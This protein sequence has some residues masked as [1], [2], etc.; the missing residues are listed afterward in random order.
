MIHSR[1][2]KIGVLGSGGYG[3]VARSYLRHTG[4][5]EIVACHDVDANVADIAAEQE[6]ASAF[7][8]L[9]AFLRHNEMEAVCINT[10]IPLHADH[11]EA[12]LAADKHVFVTK[13]V[14]VTSR[15]AKQL[16]VIAKQKNLAF[17]VG[18]HA[19]HRTSIKMIKQW[20]SSGKIGQ[21]C[22]VAITS[23]SSRGVT[24]KPDEWRFSAN[25]NP[26]GPLLQCGI[27]TIDILLD[28]IGPVRRV[29]AIRQ[30][31]ITPYDVEDN[32]MVLLDFATGVQ[33]TLTCN[34][35]TGYLHTMHWLATDGNLHLHEHVTGLNTSELYLQSRKSGDFEPWIKQDVKPDA[36]YPDDH[37]G[38]LE[39]SF[40][41]QILNGQPDY[42][43]L[44]ESIVSLEIV[45]AAVLSAHERRMVELPSANETPGQSLL[46]ATVVKPLMGHQ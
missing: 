1:K 8:E 40:A 37:M 18:H 27:H 26:G 21:L 43:N 32:F 24:G 33:A 39:K 5:F 16:A 9:G 17:M 29:M 38:V 35:T 34:Y 12:C 14:T 2:I 20:I 11:I 23:C 41:T 7:T 44:L 31:D 10:P 13:P 6:S 42:S 3:E 22:N 19:R 4:A 15:Q 30:D 46:K 36:S 45:E 25:T 28:I